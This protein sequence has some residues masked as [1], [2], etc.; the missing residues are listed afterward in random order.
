MGSLILTAQ[1][2]DEEEGLRG[3]FDDPELLTIPGFW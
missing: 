2:A 3:V 1:R